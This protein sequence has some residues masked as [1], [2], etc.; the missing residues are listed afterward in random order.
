MKSFIITGCLVGLLIV[1]GHTAFAQK[2]EYPNE[3]SGYH[4][5]GLYKLKDIDLKVST[6]EQI[7][8]I[9][10]PDCDWQF[11]SYDENWQVMFI[12]AEDYW[13][14]ARIEGNLFYTIAPKP[15][16]LGTLWRIYLRPR[17]PISFSSIVLPKVFEER[18]STESHTGNELLIY[19]DPDGLTYSVENDGPENGQR[20][21][22]LIRIGYRPPDKGWRDTF[23]VTQVE[24]MA[25]PD[26]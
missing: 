16:F 9:F 1:C 2:L 6:R 21:G 7:T 20:N 23:F 17:K 25:R 11:C 14:E 4:F 18:S 5:Y 3:L 13:R 15:Q 19:Y 12:F 24:T 8:K 22:A 26:P 10:G